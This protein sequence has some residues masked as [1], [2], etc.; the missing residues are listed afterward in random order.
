[1]KET[2]LSSL[3][4]N[5]K[6]LFDDLVRDLTNKLDPNFVFETKKNEYARYKS[7]PVKYSENVLGIKWWDEQRNIAEA[8]LK[9][10][11][12]FVKASHAVGKSFLA[13]GLVNWFYDCFN[14][15]I[16]ITT[17]P[18]QAQI[19]DV[20]WKEIRTQRH[21]R[22][23]LQPKAP[24]MESSP[25][26]FAVGY[27]ATTGDAFQGRHSDHVLIIFDEGVGVPAEFWEAAEGMM[28]GE[29]CFAAGT[30]VTGPPVDLA[31]ARW[32]EGDIIDIATAG[33]AYLTVTPNH[34]MLTPSGWVAVSSLNIGSDIVCASDAN[35]LAVSVNP[36]NYQVKA[37]IEDIA[38][39]SNN[40]FRNSS[41]M[42]RT[43]NFNSN[44]VSRKINVVRPYGALSLA[45]DSSIHQESGQVGFS[46]R[47]KESRHLASFSRLNSGFNQVPVSTLRHDS[48]ALFSR[49]RQHNLTSR[50]QSHA[51]NNSTHCST[52]DNEMFSHLQDGTFLFPERTN[53]LRILNNRRVSHHVG[54]SGR[55]DID[56]VA[57]EHTTH[58]G[59]VDSELFGNL[60]R[61]FPGKVTIDKVV[62]IVIRKF[63]GHV[64]NLQTS[65]GWYIANSVPH[66]ANKKPTEN[67]GVI[68]HNCYWVVICNPTDTSSKAYEE[69][70]NTDKW[71][72]ISISALDHPNI[73]NELQNKPIEYPGAVSLGW[74]QDRIREWCSPII[75]SDKRSAD[76]E[77]PKGTDNWYRPGALAESRMLGRWPTQ[78]S[79]A[80]WSESMWKACLVEQ[81][82][83]DTEEIEI[84]CDVAR[85]GDD[86]T[87]I[88]V[89][90]GNCALWHETHNGWDTSQTAGRLKELVK[91]YGINNYRQLVIKVDDDGV[92]GGVTD[93]KGEFN[94]QG[95]SG[96]NQALQKK[97]Y[98]NKRSEVW[99]NVCER[100]DEGRLDLT[101]L[102]SNS[103]K[104]L[105]TQVMAPT[106]KLDSSGR[107]VVEPK[108]DTK[109]RLKRSPDDADCLNITFS[110]QSKRKIQMFVI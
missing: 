108:S 43:K 69:A 52:R 24:R 38:R 80:V 19:Q 55:S 22:P 109:K 104:L 34:P 101:R 9:H 48:L 93:Q 39:P 35:G 79:Y 88:M 65:R 16:C 84:G 107:R 58:G 12:V 42:S 106:W 78:G 4:N 94:F 50:F 59:G 47:T 1:M 53:F 46:N 32:Y 90:Q 44:R 105:K 102:S 6:S 96:A 98:P 14:P 89:R 8:L 71:H 45:Y 41:S 99:F 17:A 5:K 18:T 76:F 23:G 26:H 57:S 81:E 66:I 67:Y 68:T 21:D 49:D 75:T 56:A 30:V 29:N 100:A 92:G 86:F 33:G 97:D 7:D 60:D 72:V 70:E 54:F 31:S 91:K 37:C 61:R 28:T 11:R 87:S 62:S 25:E 13:A 103:L 83:D 73:V 51:V 15:G 64:Y 20:L 36:D 85:F 95:V 10:K 40:L 3:Q 74:V 110:P 2:S 63:R 77:F 27:T 82:L